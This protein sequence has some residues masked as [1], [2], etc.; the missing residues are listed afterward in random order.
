MASCNEEKCTCPST[1]C[2]NHGKCCACINNHRE[3]N[4]LVYCMREIA[5]QK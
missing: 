1:S 2:P 3:A 4:S 5:K